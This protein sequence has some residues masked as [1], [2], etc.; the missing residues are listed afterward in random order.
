MQ[1]NQNAKSAST[2][3]TPFDTG[4]GLGLY[5]LV[6]PSG[7]KLWRL[8][9]SDGGRKRLKGLGSFPEVGLQ[10]ARGGRPWLS[11]RLWRTEA[12]N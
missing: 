3:Y 11:G 12:Q 7:S 8:K 5:L 1:P 9:Y 2:P 4:S 10:D 6:N